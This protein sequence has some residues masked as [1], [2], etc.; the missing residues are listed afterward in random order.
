MNNNNTM[1]EHINENK[2]DKLKK[3]ECKRTYMR[4]YMRE[5]N[6]RKYGKKAK[7]TEEQ[8]KEN[9]KKSHRKYYMKNRNSILTTQKK[10]VRMNRINILQK[11]LND[12]ENA[13]QILN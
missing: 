10:K 8:K 3:T 11:Q 5:Y 9:L 7:M 1:T 12:L 6:L 2:E 4:E 13:N